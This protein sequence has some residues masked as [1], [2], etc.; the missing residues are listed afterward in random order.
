MYDNGYSWDQD[1]MTIIIKH[2]GKVVMKLS[3]H[4]AIESAGYNNIMKHVRE[5]NRTPWLHRWQKERMDEVA[6]TLQGKNGQ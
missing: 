1:E 5:C 6:S 4:E 3:M 2:K